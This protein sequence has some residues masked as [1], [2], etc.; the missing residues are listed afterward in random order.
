MENTVKQEGVPSLP[1]Y[2]D[3]NELDERCGVNKAVK[4]H[5]HEYRTSEVHS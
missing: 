1:S 2:Q 3:A 5:F 4:K